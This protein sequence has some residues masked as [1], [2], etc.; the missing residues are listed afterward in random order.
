MSQENVERIRDAVVAYNRGDLDA[1]LD[2]YWT[3]DIDYRAVE[4]APDDHGPIHG[5]AEMRAYMQDWFDTFDDLT[6]EPLEVIDAGQDQAVAVVRFGGRAKLSGVEADL[7]F[8]VVYTL[9]DGKVARGREYWT[10]EQALEA[11]GLSE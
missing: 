6:V 4:G 10:K 2:E 11:A 1:F 5:K 9:R 7:T 8:A 3:D